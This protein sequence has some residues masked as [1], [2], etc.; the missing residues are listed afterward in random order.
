EGGVRGA[1]L[2]GRRHPHLPLTLPQGFGGQHTI[3]H[4]RISATTSPQPRAGAP[5]LPKRI[6][7][8]LETVRTAEKRSAA[9]KAAQEE[10]LKNYYLSQDAEYQRLRNT[11]NEYVALAPH[12]RLVGVQD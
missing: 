6:A 7:D 2:A 1:G 5:Q 4:F 11:V 3:G 8:L 10:E 12:A 9:Q